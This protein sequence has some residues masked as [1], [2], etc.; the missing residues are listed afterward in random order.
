AKY[1]EERWPRDLAADLA[2]HQIGLMLYRQK[3][4]PEAVQ[5]LSTITPG[6][7]AYAM[8][9]YKLAEIA[10]EA[11]RDKAPPLP[12][13]KPADYHQRALAAL[14]AVTEPGPDADGAVGHAYF[15][16]KARL[17]EELF[18]AKKFADMDRVA[19]PLLPKLA[20]Y[21]FDADPQRDEAVRQY[22]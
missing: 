16:A 8:S 9:Q 4:L 2:R 12:R 19:R 14:E 11:E 13:D 5:K 7:P 10:L 1:V 18:A 17:G 6:Y 22:L 15:V 3:K 20:Q 21:H